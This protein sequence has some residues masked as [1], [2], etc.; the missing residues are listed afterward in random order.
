MRE[1]FTVKEQQLVAAAAAAA[2]KT[3][4]SGQQVLD[5]DRKTRELQ[6]CVVCVCVLFCGISICSLVL[7][8][9]KL[10]L[11]RLSELHSSFLYSYLTLP[12]P[13]DAKPCP[14]WSGVI[15]CAHWLV[16]LPTC[17]SVDQNLQVEVAVIRHEHCAVAAISISMSGDAV[18]CDGLLQL[19]QECIERQKNERPDL[20]KKFHNVKDDLTTR[21]QNACNQRDEAR[22]QVRMY[23]A[24]L[25]PQ[26][27]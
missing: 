4:A 9:S 24:H 15:H 25:V 16:G 6:V 26:C 13:I 1:A 5:L 3:A 11:F 17:R 2:A 23:S 18:G 21:L 8:A 22:G 7:L 12:C 10:I 14:Q 27:V 19:L 20:E